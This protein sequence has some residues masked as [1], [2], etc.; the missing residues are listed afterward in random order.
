MTEVY[1]VVAAFGTNADAQ[2]AV[3]K[4]ER[5]GFMKS[6]MSIE[7]RVSPIHQQA[8]KMDHLGIGSWAITGA[9]LGGLWGFLINGEQFQNKKEDVRLIEPLLSC[10]GFVVKGACVFAGMSFVNLSMNGEISRMQI[11]HDKPTFSVDPYL[12]VLHGTPASITQAG[13]VLRAA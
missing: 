7:N 3:Q 13:D 1:S 9:L 11:V 2:G 5:S 12:L 8:P 4:L 10:L 6:V